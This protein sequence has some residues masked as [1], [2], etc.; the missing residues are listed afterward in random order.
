MARNSAHDATR[1]WAGR[2]MR[3]P[4]TVA[5]TYPRPPLFFAL[6]SMSMVFMGCGTSPSPK[7]EE[8][9]ATKPAEPA[10]PAE[11]Q[12]AAEALLGAET[13]VLAFGD[14]AKNGKQQV[15]VAN[16]VPKTPKDS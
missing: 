11:I 7:P 6:M 16:V 13:K 3:P 14:L 12:S 1:Y 9:A 2:I 10:V 5:P 8:P 15:L 4:R